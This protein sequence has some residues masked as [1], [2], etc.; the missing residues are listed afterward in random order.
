ME[1]VPF[2]EIVWY[3]LPEVA[4]DRPQDLE[5]RWAKGEWLGHARHSSEVLVGTEKGIV[6]AWAIRRMADGQQEDGDMVRNI[7]GSPT[8]WKLD[9]SEDRQL[10]EMED[11]NDPALNPDLEKSGRETDW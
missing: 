5:E 7:K 10:V 8:N 1:V 6:K 3:R 9:A 11:R 4:V 2:G